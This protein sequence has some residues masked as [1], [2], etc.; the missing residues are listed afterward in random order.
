MQRLIFS[1][2]LLCL[3]WT[4]ALP[5]SAAGIAFI[6]VPAAEGLPTLEGAV[7]YPCAALPGEVKVGMSILQATKDCPL[8]GRNLPLVVV[9]H[10][11]G[12]SFVG[13]HDTAEALADAGFVVAAINHPSDSGRSPENLRKPVL[14]ALTD[15]PAD[16]KRLV[17]FMLGAWP[18][19]AK[20]D[21]DR[22]GFF[23][24]SRGGFTGLAIIGGNPDFHTA[25]AQLCPDTMQTPDCDKIR[26]TGLPGD[27]MNHD[28][29]IKAAVIADPLFGRFFTGL[30]TVGVP[31][32]LW[33][34]ERGGDGVLPDDAAAVARNLGAKP[35]YHRVAGAAHF[36]FL[37][38]CNARMSQHLPDICLDG[39]A[40]D[41]TAFHAQFNAQIVAFFRVKLVSH[42]ARSDR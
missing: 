19:A 23:G 21:R 7:W 12:G 28:P 37:A 35:E 32:Q 2:A 25:F 22:I 16:M 8:E 1:C 36:A 30:Q 5:A 18:D 15:R 41:R 20:I 39:P 27:S 24:F 40:F 38:P 33:A 9:S 3:G 13:H 17:D 42:D 34:S 6:K 31:V 26:K 14:A 11:F 4:A 29:R 10:G